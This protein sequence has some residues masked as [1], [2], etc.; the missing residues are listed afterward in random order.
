MALAGRSL[1]QARWLSRSP[2]RCFQLKRQHAAAGRDDRGPARRGPRGVVAAA[3]GSCWTQADRSAASDALVSER[4][5]EFDERIRNT[6]DLTSRLYREVIFRAGCVVPRRASGDAP[7][8]ATW[9]AAWQKA[10][11]EVQGETTEVTAT[12][13]RS[14]TPAEPLVLAEATA[15]RPDRPAGRQA[16]GRPACGSRPPTARGCSRSWWP[17]MAAEIDLDRLRRKVVAAGHVTT[18]WPRAQRRP[19]CWSSFPSRLTTSSA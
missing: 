14:S 2:S 9:P 15:W 4:I 12:S 7:V 3:V 8:V 13:S 10:R 16:R 11:L 6:D 5:D 19:S 1:V 18:R 17:T